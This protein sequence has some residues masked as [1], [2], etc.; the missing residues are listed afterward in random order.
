MKPAFKYIIGIAIT[1]LLLWIILPYADISRIVFYVS[2]IKIGYLLLGFMFYALAY[3]F[4]S[5]RMR[6]LTGKTIPFSLMFKVLCVHGAANSS[7]PFKA[8]E[9]VYV[10]LLRRIR[11]NLTSLAVSSLM[12]IR[13]F[14]VIVISFIIMVSL[15]FAR[16]DSGYVGMLVKASALFFVAAIF[17]LFMLMFAGRKIVRAIERAAKLLR[18][19]GLGIV[20]KALDGL[21]KVSGNFAMLK[22]KAVM[23]EA[24]AYSVITWLMLVMFYYSILEGISIDVGLW[25]AVL[26]TGLSVMFFTLLPFQSLLGFGAVEG[27]WS[28][29]LLT[30]GV[31]VGNAVNVSFVLHLFQIMSFVLLGAYGLVSLKANKNRKLFI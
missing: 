23:A 26:G 19:A 29:A 20:K 12:L 4:R 13:L 28:V 1:V 3:V 7:L 15:F 31:A 10:Y 6:L 27:A 2:T 24:F 21:Y 22:S 18:I 16:P 25:S 8:G 14:D 30:M 5:L 9:L 11:K 17:A